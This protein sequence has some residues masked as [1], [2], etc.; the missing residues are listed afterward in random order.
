L[1]SVQE[2][3][4]IAE[5]KQREYMHDVVFAVPEFVEMYH[6]IGAEPEKDETFPNVIMDDALGYPINL[7]LS[8]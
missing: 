5:D 8:E 6:G 4:F 2:A 3:V 1:V 7:R